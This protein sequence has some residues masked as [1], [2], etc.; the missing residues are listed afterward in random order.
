MNQRIDDF[1]VA[2]SEA[3]ANARQQ[4]R[5]AAHRLHAAGYRDVDVADGDALCCE[6]HG[7]EA[8]AADLVDR[9]RGDV[10]REAAVQ[11]RLAGRVLPVTGLDDVAHD[12][13]V[14]N[15]GIDAG[16]RDGFA[17]DPGAEIG[18]RQILERAKKLSRGGS[19]GGDDD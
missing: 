12:A 17:H 1:A 5:R 9:Q 7:L 18:G 10:I 16:A 14:D 8:G 6:H 11:S 2:H 13:F 19:D 15:R 3:F 4:V